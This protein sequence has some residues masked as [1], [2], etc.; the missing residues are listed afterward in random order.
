MENIVL[1]DVHY[2]VLHQI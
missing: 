1:E 2:I